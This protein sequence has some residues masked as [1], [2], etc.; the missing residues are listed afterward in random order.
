[1]SVHARGA[2]LVWADFNADGFGDLAI[3]SP[4][5][6]VRGDGLFCSEIT[7]DVADAGRVDVV[8]G[9][10]TGLGPFGLQSLKQGVCEYRVRRG[11]GG[12]RLAG[13]WR[14][15][16][17]RARG[18][19]QCRWWR[20]PGHR[21]TRGRSRPVRQARRRC[22][23]YSARQR[24]RLVD[25]FGNQLISQDTPG[26]GGAAED[27]DQFGRVLATGNFSGNRE[28]LVVGIPFE[29]VGDNAQRDGGAI[30]VF[31]R[32]LPIVTTDDSVFISQS[33]LANVSA[34][35]GDLMGWALA[36][37][38]FDSDGRDDLAVGTPG[39]D[40]GNTVDAGMVSVLYGA[41]GGLSTTRI[42]H[43]HQDSSGILDFAEGGDQFGYALS[44]WNYGRTRHADLAIG[45]PFEEVQSAADASNQRDA[46]AV[47]VIYGSSTGL[48]SSGNQLW[49]QD[50]VGINDTAEPDDRF[51][52][53]LY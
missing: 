34:E 20:R 50:T 10:P 42:Q 11:W 43:W 31:F 32:G 33:N 49:T 7:L 41:S 4:N 2:A 37:G 24:H 25:E 29:D 39:E 15:I 9:S 17:R 27:G 44:A 13:V 53:A 22:G 3:G 21:R 45:A 48:N 52:S 14:P 30:Q 36:V 16:R 47:H 46:G 18:D 12:S 28:A 19:A 40:V 51:G 35:S 1:M 6:D 23:P 26:V 38:D 8:Y 5:A